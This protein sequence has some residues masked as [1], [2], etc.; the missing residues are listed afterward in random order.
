MHPAVLDALTA[1]RFPERPASYLLLYGRSKVETSQ[2]PS[3]SQPAVSKAPRHRPMKSTR[4]QELESPVLGGHHG[5]RVSQRAGEPSASPRLCSN[6]FS[7]CI[8]TS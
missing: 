3:K 5:R 4:V 1:C 7:W 2:V 6:R 8:R